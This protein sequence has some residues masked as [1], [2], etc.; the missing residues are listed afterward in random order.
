MRKTTLSAI[1]LVGGSAMLGACGGGSLFNRDRPDEFAVQRQAPLVVP[2]DFALVP[3][4]PG[5]PRPADTTA[6]QQALDT[7][8]GG[9]AP[10][11]GVESSALDKAG[12]ADPGIRSDVG[13][14]QTN[15][16]DKA[17][18]TRAIVSAPQGDGRE[19]Q[20]V[21]PPAGATAASGS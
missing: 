19:A 9:T 15:T 7:M 13:D 20:A 2:P 14:P 6:S 8:F 12:A 18:A 1:L 5:A 11:S 10:R 4:A 21:I 3:P 16:V 17:G